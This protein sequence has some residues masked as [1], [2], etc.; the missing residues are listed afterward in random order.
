M[1]KAQPET[2]SG[3]CRTFLIV[4]VGYEHQC[5]EGVLLFPASLQ[6][7][8]FRGLE[9]LFLL[10]EHELAPA[11]ESAQPAVP[12]GQPFSQAAAPPL[13]VSRLASFKVSVLFQNNASW[14]GTVTWNEKG[15]ELCFRSALE[16]V[17]LM[18]NALSSILA[19]SSPPQ[20]S[21]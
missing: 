9:E 18:D 8:P 6:V 2:V 5:L 13:P 3:S 12:A 17:S 1:K 7:R 14:Q 20:Q 19:S 21:D 4:V 16:L 11:V 10:M 15:R